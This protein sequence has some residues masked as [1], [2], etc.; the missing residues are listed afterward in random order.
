MAYRYSPSF[1]RAYEHQETVFKAEPARK[2][3][4]GRSVEAA[5]DA[6]A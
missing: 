3:V 4:K 1:F 2:V 5:K 6:V